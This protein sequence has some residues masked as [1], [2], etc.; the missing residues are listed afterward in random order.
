MM[1]VA[2]R[3]FTRDEDAQAFQELVDRG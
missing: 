3:G 2:D 1:N